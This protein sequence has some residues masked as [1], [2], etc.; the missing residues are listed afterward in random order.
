MI[1]NNQLSNKWLRASVLGCIWASSEIVLGSF[2]HNMRIPFSSNFL[3][4]IGIILLISVS[5]IWNEKGLIWRSGL[6]CALMKSISPSA[7]IFGPM[8]AIF[9]EALLI[10]FAIRIFQKN[11][12]S[13]IIGGMLAMS[14]N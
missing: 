5:H 2:L 6:V 14:W 4:A 9:S 12:F 10:E 8:V 11:I 1:I 13:Y 3:T 7:M